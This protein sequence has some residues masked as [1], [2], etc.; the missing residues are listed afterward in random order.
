MAAP[1]IAIVGAGPAGTA[2]AITLARAGTRPVL[3]DKADFPR[4]KCCGDGLTTLALRHLADLGLPPATVASWTDVDRAVLTA[5]S[6]REVTVPLPRGRGA[7]A[8]VTRRLDL[9]DQ[10]VRLAREAGADVRTGT[11]VDDVDLVAGGARL[12]TSVG[13]LDVDLVL[14][15][16]GMWSPIR[17]RLGV[18]IP[19]YRG[20]WHAFRQYHRSDAPGSRELR[21][22]FEA[23]LL[24]GYAWSFPLPD[25]RC[26][27]GFGVRRSGAL[28]GGELK[29]IMAELLRRPAL[30]ASLGAAEPEERP[31]AW[32]IP[33]RIPAATLHHGPVLFLGD[34]A[35]A[36]DPLTG[37]GIGQALET[38]ALAA[39]A[40]LAGASGA[41]ERYASSV[42]RAL[43]ADHRMAE[44]CSR[45]LAHRRG[46]EG[47][48]WLVDRS[49]WTRRNFARW[50][51]EDEPR[52]LVVTPRRWH[53]RPYHRDGAALPA[54]SA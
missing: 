31:T 41:G 40:V 4:D 26:N 49:N 44:A 34:A 45:I 9:D 25:G 46:T 2:A 14:A 38:G 5:P 42:R 54:A 11:T 15:A 16:D 24:P 30:R 19:G 8:A 1:R 52:A 47:A 10:L 43:V 7:F 36:T 37:E 28:D 29:R 33:A 53:R 50:M 18:G 13:P 39:E 35:M 48:L 17:R 12:S 3:L 23:D 21:V 51:F 27:V 6:G 20:D 32:P 22:F